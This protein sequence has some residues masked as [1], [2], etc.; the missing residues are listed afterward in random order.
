MHRVFGNITLWLLM[1]LAGGSSLMVG[2]VLTAVEIFAPPGYFVSLSDTPASTAAAWIAF[3]ATTGEVFTET[4]AAAQMPIA[5]VTKLPAAAVAYTTT[6]LWATTT[7]RYDDVAASG[8]AGKLVV[9]EVYNLYTLL[10]PLLLESSNDA[11]A[12]FTRTAPTLVDDMNAYASSLGL[13][14]TTFVDTSGLARGN[15]STA[16]DLAHLLADM[17]QV[18]RHVIDITGLPLYLS[19]DTGWVNNSPFA[20]SPEYVGGKHGYTPEA[21]H[22]A[23]AI[24]EEHFGD[25]TRAVGYV[26]L[27]SDDL[28]GDMKALRDYVTTHV[29][30]K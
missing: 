25:K 13:T 15:V 18:N 9:G 14:H 5:S 10:F 16:K 27:G 26:I 24:F 2:G 23:V 8:R 22:T 17:Y 30:L 20:S 21:Q 1:A 19:P 28:A 12:V 4:N 11:A 7:V 29:S 6:D 3:D